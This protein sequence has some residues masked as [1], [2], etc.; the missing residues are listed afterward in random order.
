MQVGVVPHH[1]LDRRER[2]QLLGVGQELEIE[3]VTV[4]EEVGCP[5]ERLAQGIHPLEVIVERELEDVL[6]LRGD[7]RPA[8]ALVSARFRFRV[9][10]RVTAWRK[11]VFSSPARTG[12]SANFSWVSCQSSLRRKSVPCSS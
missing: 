8:V 9:A 6:P 4:G 5:D 7:R 10:S 2:D 1:H 12:W 11:S 3:D